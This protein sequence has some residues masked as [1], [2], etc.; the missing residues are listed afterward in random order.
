[1]PVEPWK[2]DDFRR[3]VKAGAEHLSIVVADAIVEQAIE[4]SF[5]SIGVFQEL[6]KGECAQSQ[7]L[8]RLSGDW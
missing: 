8:Q 3:V 6:L 1:M 4:S 5:S 2:K 7:V